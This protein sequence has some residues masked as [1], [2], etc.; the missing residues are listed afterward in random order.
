[1]VIFSHDKISRF[2]N[3]PRL[4]DKDYWQL[5]KPI[6]RK[7]ESELGILKIDGFIE[8]KPYT[9]ENEIACW[10]WCHNKK[11]NVKGMNI[12][13]FHYSGILGDDGGAFQLPLAWEIVHKTEQYY[14]KST[15]KVKRRADKSKNEIL[16]DRLRILHY[17]NKLSYQY[18]VWDSWFSSKENL[19]MVH[20]ELKKT[21][22]V[23][24]KSNRQVALTLAD[25]QKGHFQSLDS[26]Q[27]QPK[28]T[29]PSVC[30]RIGFSCSPHQKILYKQRPIARGVVPDH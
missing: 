2:L 29:L 8:E 5:L 9:D 20:H 18:M 7:V 16:R 14:D 12:L 21:F 1:M 15:D 13:H 17:L 3:Q 4:S 23:A 27:L 28:P 6:I 30:E 11:T 22:V 19:Q 26:L 25:K 10:H 24:L